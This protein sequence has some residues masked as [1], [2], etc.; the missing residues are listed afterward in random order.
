MRKDSTIT[1]YRGLSRWYRA[2]VVLLGVG[3]SNGLEAFC[4]AVVLSVIEAI[5]FRLRGSSLTAFPGQMRMTYTSML[6]LFPWLALN[7]LFWLATIGTAAQV[8]PA[9]CL[10][11]L[12]GNR[13]RRCRWT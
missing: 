2:V 6:A 9:R 3:L 12:P 5:P 8:P 4:A 10:S 7:V 13:P 11:L 1:M